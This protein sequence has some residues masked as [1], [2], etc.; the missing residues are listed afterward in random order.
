MANQTKV[1]T[2]ERDVYLHILALSPT[3]FDGWGSDKDQTKDK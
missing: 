3:G 2:T 1:A